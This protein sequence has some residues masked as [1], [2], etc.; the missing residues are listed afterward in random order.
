M[1]TDFNAVPDPRETRLVLAPPPGGSVAPEL[2]QQFIRENQIPRWND[3]QCIYEL[4]RISADRWAMISTF[5]STTCRNDID[6]GKIQTLSRMPLDLLTLVIDFATQR[7]ITSGEVLFALSNVKVEEFHPFIQLVEAHDLLQKPKIWRALVAMPA[8]YRENFIHFCKAKQ[9]DINGLKGGLIFQQHTPEFWPE[10]DNFLKQVEVSDYVLGR[11]AEMSAAACLDYMRF[12]SMNKVDDWNAKNVLVDIVQALRQLIWDFVC[13]YNLSVSAFKKMPEDMWPR[14][15]N[16]IERHAQPGNTKLSEY[17]IDVLIKIPDEDW[18]EF[19]HF[20]DT[21]QIH[22][23]DMIANY[24][25]MSALQRNYLFDFIQKYQLESFEI[26]TFSEV[27]VEHWPRFIAL[28]EENQLTNVKQLSAIASRTPEE[29]AACADLIVRR[30]ISDFWNLGGLENISSQHFNFLCAFVDEYNID[31][32]HVIYGLAQIPSIRQWVSIYTLAQPLFAPPLPAEERGC[33]M[34]TLYEITKQEYRV[35][36]IMPT[37]DDNERLARIAVVQD[38]TARG[39]MSQNPREYYEQMRQILRTP[40]NQLGN[41]HQAAVANARAINVHAEGREDGTGHALQQLIALPYD[42]SQIDNDYAALIAYL[43]NFPGDF[44]RTSAQFVLGLASS[45]T[46]GFAPLSADSV[47]TSYDLNITGKE[48]LARCWHYIQHGEFMGV[49]D[50]EALARD[51]ENARV[52]L[53]RNLADA[54]EDDAVVCNPGKLQ[55][56]AVGILQGRLESVHIDREIP[57]VVQSTSA[58]IPT[59]TAVNPSLVRNTVAASLRDFL[60]QYEAAVG[61]QV[62]LKSHV[63]GWLQAERGLNGDAYQQYREDFRKELDDY[64][65]LSDLPEETVVEIANAH[66]DITTLQTEPGENLDHIHEEEL[67][68]SEATVPEHNTVSNAA[69]SLDEV[70]VRHQQEQVPLVTIQ[71]LKSN[72][73]NLLNTLARNVESGSKPRWTSGGSTSQKVQVLRALETFVNNQDESW[74]LDVANQTKL[75][76]LVKSICGTHR[77]WA[78]V[79]FG[80]PASLG[81]FLTLVRTAPEGYGT[82]AAAV[83]AL[84]TAVLASQQ[85]SRAISTVDFNELLDGM[86]VGQHSSG[87]EL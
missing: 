77:N 56:I 68:D 13:K 33:V 61:S 84:E 42:T 80:P 32:E 62:E 16:F 45:Q 4:S 70:E 82:S 75:L 37:Y 11:L 65:R 71:P 76:T 2:V 59:D 10:I 23:F 24:A 25:E 30:N 26:S 18:P 19:N 21:H 38:R 40:M 35:D 39:L 36:R 6:G 83:N 67:D 20:L 15:S 87:H 52:G 50:A 28:I 12:I 44:T 22:E 17:T 74:I 43:N 9:Y 48:F 31:D 85:L 79:H 51:R 78:P 55:H 1:P 14:V 47:I 66:N 86:P 64:L 53:I 58:E 7:N 63:D 72:Y 41:M 27:P 3:R 5:L 60:L 81:E 46:E 49:T 54:Y 8:Q 57:I 34:H 73:T 29:W 69:L